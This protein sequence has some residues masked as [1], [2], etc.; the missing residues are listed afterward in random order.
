[1]YLLYMHRGKEIITICLQ[2]IYKL[3]NSLR[4]HLQIGI[5]LSNQCVVCTSAIINQPLNP[6]SKLH[7]VLIVVQAQ[8]EGNE[9]F[10]LYTCQVINHTKSTNQKYI[11]IC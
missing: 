7:S 5:S 3:Y 10:R 9:V 2:N 11:T 8:F 1:M 6:S 4:F